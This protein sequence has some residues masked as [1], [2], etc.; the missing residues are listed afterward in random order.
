[1][2]HEFETLNQA[3]SALLVETCALLNERALGYVAFSYR[4]QRPLVAR[5]C[6]RSASSMVWH[7]KLYV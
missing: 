7:L 6:L 1:M 4:L 3:A 5:M 2:A